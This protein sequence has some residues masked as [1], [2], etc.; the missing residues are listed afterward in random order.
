MVSR[1]RG[2]GHQESLLCICELEAEVATGACQELTMTLVGNLDL[3]DKS[4][5][6]KIHGPARNWHVLLVK[7]TWERIENSSKFLDPCR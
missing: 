7:H 4:S 1:E 6:R 2:M 3:H 5:N